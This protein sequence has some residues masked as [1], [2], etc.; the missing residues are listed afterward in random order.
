MQTQIP[1]RTQM[2]RAAP[3]APAARPEPGNPLTT[4]HGWLLMLVLP[5]AV[6]W[7]PV[8]QVQDIGTLTVLDCV[9]VLLAS[10]TL[11]RLFST[12]SRPA[13]TG[14]ALRIAIYGF[15]PAIFEVFGALLFDPQSRLITGFLQHAKR[16]GLPAIIPL[17]M[18]LCPA[19][20]VPRIRV[21][22]VA[23][24]LIT[25]L[26]P[27]T[28]FADSLPLHGVSADQGGAKEDVRGTGSLSNPND[29]AYVSLL[30]A[31]IGLS[32]AAGRRDQRFRRR[33]WASVAIS[34]GL[35]G[36]V[37]SASRSGIAA[38]WLAA[39]YIVF[40]SSLSF[41]KKL[42]LVVILG[43]T[44]L[45][46]WQASVVYQD[47]MA[48]AIRENIQE[49]STVARVEAQSAALRTWLAHPFGVGFSNMQ[50]AT[51]E[52][53]QTAQFFTAVAGSDS[54]YVDFLV[55]TGAL[56]FAC[57]ILCFWNC[58]RLGGVRKMPTGG[59]YLKA[60]MF[61][62]YCF[63]LATVS[64]ASYSVAPF[65]FAVAGLTGCLREASSPKEAR[66]A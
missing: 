23:A 43:V 38:A 25:V 51:A 24:L 57:L 27:F 28:P 36:I 31:L 10:T 63:G 46:G 8:V 47:R 12:K 55:G 3:A 9:L 48:M 32:H 2:L 53:S 66:R 14:R 52:F 29:F 21:V 58:W 5:F 39:A 49:A 15:A 18:L 54:I 17:A 20:R 45:A 65:F 30:G 61:A 41:L 7:I 13:S 11:L 42:S 59:T 16:F 35:L 62:A 33:W 6:L 34:A 50:P 1:Y 60:G 44:M 22:A 4:L 64:P 26:I 56:G 19:K 37:T 40:C